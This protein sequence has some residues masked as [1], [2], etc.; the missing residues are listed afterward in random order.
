MFQFIQKKLRSKKLLNGCLLLGIICFM[1]VMAMIPMFADGAL[2]DVIQYEFSQDTIEKNTFSCVVGRSDS[3]EPENLSSMAD[4]EKVITNYTDKWNKYLDLPV[5]ATQIIYEMSLGKMQPGLKGKQE[6]AEVVTFNDFDN[7]L[8]ITEVDGSDRTKG[9]DAPDIIPCYIALST[10]DKLDLTVGEVME[11]TFTKDANEQPLRMRVD[12]LIAEKNSSDYYWYKS[13]R[14][15]GTVMVVKP[16]VFEKIIKE[17]TPGGTKKDTVKY[18]VT[19]LLDYREINQGNIFLIKDYIGQLKKLDKSFKCDFVPLIDKYSD[20]EK[21]INAIIVS[22]MIPIVVLLLIF[23]YMVADR[24]AQSEELEINCLRS[25]GLSRSVIIRQYILQ[26]FLLSLFASAPGC[27]LGFLMCKLSALSVDF[28]TFKMRDTTFYRFRIEVIFFVLIAMLVSIAVMVIPVIGRSKNTV[29]GAKA[30]RQTS[31]KTFVEKYFVDVILLVLSIYLLYNYRRQS[32]VM[33][34]DVLAGK[35]L[36][37]MCL[38]DAELFT[39]GA[40]F[41][42]IRIS[43]YIITAVFKLGEKKW[44][45]ATF[46]AFLEV[47]RSGRKSWVISVFLILTIAMGIYDAGLSRTVNQNI[48]QR[49]QNDMGAEVVLKPLYT[50]RL[51]G[52]SET[53]WK[54]KG[55]SYND[56]LGLKTNGI[57]TDMTAVSRLDKLTVGT[58]KGTIETAEMIAVNTKQIGETGVFD[59]RLNSHHW[60]RELNSLAE[61]T[62]GVII[63]QNMAD[64]YK[65]KTGDSIDLKLMSPIAGSNKTVTNMTAQVVGIVNCF[66]GF[67][68]YTYEKK[69][70]KIVCTENYLVVI[71][72]AAFKIYYGD[73]PIEVWIKLDKGHTTEDVRKYMEDHNMM[74]DSLK[75][76]DRELDTKLG[77]SEVLITNGLFNISFIISMII[78]VL[79]F[80]I[81]WLTS[82]HS[83]QTYIGVYRAMGMGMKSVNGMLIKE[84]I[85]STVVSIILSVIAGLLTSKL[86][87]KL[88]SCIYLPEKHSIPMIIYSSSTGMIRIG[89]VMAVAVIICMVI[90]IRFIKNMSITEAIK[91]GE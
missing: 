14:K 33:I 71:N 83:R 61:V 64:E 58:K 27:L 42:M 88:I 74:I 24:I 55:P 68:R 89:I 1:A 65:V 51:A 31:N 60:F 44:K 9:S 19:E 40:A 87:I 47:I 63:S 37:P 7:V 11:F 23:I 75:S 17:Y 80:L 30:K 39:F 45:P 28:L 3:I 77:T 21:N 49:T 90:I 22:S 35:V 81:Y 2:D 10:M 86:F 20:V 25:R 70:D 54:C 29:I 4:A 56:I 57:V 48:R 52:E 78:C 18:S 85:L 73:Y 16:E 34:N 6:N 15:C 72:E 5:V 67:Q 26:S 8:E 36:D 38:I 82:I 69:D 41:F 53:S 32:D 84:H 13:L 66:P 12:G 46:A 79:G 50:V 91:M 76:M 59:I 43:K 62:N